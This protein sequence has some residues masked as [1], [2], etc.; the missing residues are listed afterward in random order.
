MNHANI[1]STM[2]Y[3]KLSKSSRTNIWIIWLSVFDE[4][5]IIYKE[6]ISDKFKKTNICEPI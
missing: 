2:I 4:C 5:V 1:N 3:A 6:D